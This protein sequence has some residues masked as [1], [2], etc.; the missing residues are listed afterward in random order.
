M[1]RLLVESGADL[2]L[3]NQRGRT[4]LMTAEKNHQPQIVE[5]LAAA[6]TRI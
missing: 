4:P 6:E 1:T 5:F 3:K 2:H